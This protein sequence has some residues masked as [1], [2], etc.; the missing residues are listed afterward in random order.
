MGNRRIIMR[1]RSEMAVKYVV[2]MMG[3]VEPVVVG[4]SVL[5]RIF[6]GIKIAIRQ[7]RF[8]VGVAV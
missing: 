2:S 5:G 7:K 3:Q 1:E 6:G 4:Y 8:A